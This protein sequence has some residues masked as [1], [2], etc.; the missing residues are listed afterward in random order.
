VIL[1]HAQRSDPMT[2]RA[3]HQPRAVLRQV[4]APTSGAD[5]LRR[6]PALPLG[7]KPRADLAI[8]RGLDHIGRQHVS[9]LIARALCLDECALGCRCL[10]P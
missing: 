4:R 10:S 3:P 1:A 9:F 5:N 2:P 8:E 7:V 6:P